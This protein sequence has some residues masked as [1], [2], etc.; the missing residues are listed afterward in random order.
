MP[1]DTM[2]ETRR[3]NAARGVEGEGCSAGGTNHQRHL[4]THNRPTARN[5]G[6]GSCDVRIVTSLVVSDSALVI[7]RNS[8]WRELREYSRLLTRD[9]V[10]RLRGHMLRRRSNPPTR[11]NTKVWRVEGA[12]ER[13]HRGIEDVVAEGRSRKRPGCRQRHKRDHE[14]RP[15]QGPGTLGRQGVQQRAL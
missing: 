10:L 7:G 15:R 4:A 3:A 9:S 12:E 8:A 13:D 1:T 5:T 2:A 14:P 11:K 6:W